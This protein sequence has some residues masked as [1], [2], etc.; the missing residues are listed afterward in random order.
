[1]NAYKVSMMQNIAF[2]RAPMYL[3]FAGAFVLG[4]IYVN[5]GPQAIEPPPAPRPWSD[6]SNAVQPPATA[7]DGSLLRVNPQARHGEPR[8]Y[9][10]DAQ[11]RDEATS[12]YTLSAFAGV[13]LHQSGFGQQ[14][15][16]NPVGGL[17]FGY[18][19][20]FDDEPIEQF[21]TETQRGVRLAGGLEIEGFYVR[22]EFDTG[23]NDVEANHA[24][25][26]LN[27]LLKAKW[28]RFMIYGG[29][30]AGMVWTETGATG[31]GGS[32]NSVDFA[33]QAI[34]G[35]DVYFD[36]QWSIFTEYKWLNIDGLS[37]GGFTAGRVEHHIM[38][39]GLRHHF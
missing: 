36:P 21:F 3:A 15:E 16:V 19:W 23:G 34:G 24:F 38:T 30:G 31:G 13:N 18:T 22:N 2:S 9:I 11:P 5:A 33:Y 10:I 6:S 25:F 32:D 14:S 37:L 29:P 39:L 35:L 7:P 20:P 1:M 4:T 28:S 17:K 8:P 26:M 12:G 27:A